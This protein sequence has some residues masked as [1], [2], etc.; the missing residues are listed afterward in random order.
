MANLIDDAITFFNRN[1]NIPNA[2]KTAQTYRNLAI[3]ITKNYTELPKND[4]K[5]VYTPKAFSVE[6]LKS[7]VENSVRPQLHDVSY[8]TETPYKDK[9]MD[10]NKESYSREDL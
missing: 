3:D 9:D 1:E 6:L 2:I 8:E 7:D 10:A 5:M 4:E